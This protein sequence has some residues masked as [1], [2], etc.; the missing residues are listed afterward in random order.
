MSVGLSRPPALD[1]N[2]AL[3]NRRLCLFRFPTAVAFFSVNV[4]D[5]EDDE[6]DEKFVNNRTTSHTPE[7]PTF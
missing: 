5:D 3:S 1:P 7:S 4:H 2:I 6:D